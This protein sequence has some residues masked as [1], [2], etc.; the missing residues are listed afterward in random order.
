[1]EEPLGMH[2]LYL[3]YSNEKQKTQGYFDI[4][5]NNFKNTRVSADVNFIKTIDFCI[6]S[7][8]LYIVRGS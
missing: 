3:V 6:N 2:P 8:I 5:L 4:I 1:M 7:S